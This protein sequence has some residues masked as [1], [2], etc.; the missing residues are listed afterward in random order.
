M[1]DY[2]TY[3]SKAW[4]KSVQVQQQLPRSNILQSPHVRV[5]VFHAHRTARED[6]EGLLSQIQI[7][8]LWCNYMWNK[9]PYVLK[10]WIKFGFYDLFAYVVTS[11]SFFGQIVT[12]C[13]TSLFFSFSVWKE[14]HETS[15]C[16]FC[17]WFWW[18]WK[19]KLCSTKREAHWSI[20]SCISRWTS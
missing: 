14:R 9:Y 17:S 5:T 20:W 10:L 6:P 11:F 16:W 18:S 2:G 12:A 3:H 13:L 15:N 7:A 1:V 19:S 8:F 4:A